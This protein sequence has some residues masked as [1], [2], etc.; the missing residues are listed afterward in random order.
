MDARFASSVQDPFAM[1]AK[2]VSVRLSYSAH[3]GELLFTGPKIYYVFDTFS[4]VPIY[5]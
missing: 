5:P 2:D 4:P 1:P 3:L